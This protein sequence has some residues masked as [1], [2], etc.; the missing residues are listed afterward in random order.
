MKTLRNAGIAIIVGFVVGLISLAV[1]LKTL[2][3]NWDSF[4]E[5]P[6]IY[7][8]FLTAIPFE[9]LILMGIVSLIFLIFTY[10]GFIFLGRKFKNRLLVTSSWIMLF[11]LILSQIK[12]M[13]ISYFIIYQGSESVALLATQTVLSILFLLSFIV[14]YIL[15]GVSLKKLKN[16]EM[17]K[18]TG[19]LYV[20]SGATMIILVGSALL[21]VAQIFAAVMFLKASKKFDGK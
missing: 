9:F 6:E 8:T 21:I 4:I 2:F 14:L 1:M 10:A 20:I 5:N 13:I 7:K 18:T 15:L 16:V 17:A 12:D 3:S 19:L 11:V